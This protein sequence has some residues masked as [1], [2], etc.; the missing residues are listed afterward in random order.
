M[1]HHLPQTSFYFQIC[2]QV[3]LI[4]N[5]F[6]GFRKVHPMEKFS[7]STLLQQSVRLIS[8]A[9][10]NAHS[11]FLKERIRKLFVG[12]EQF[13][14]LFPK[15]VLTAN[16]PQIVFS[17]IYLQGLTDSLPIT[18]TWSRDKCQSH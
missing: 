14:L 8:P 9:G 18:N 10:H 16:S 13:F 1:S 11:C 15:S 2:S 3:L 6:N 5:T 12:T 7:G 4:N 17:L